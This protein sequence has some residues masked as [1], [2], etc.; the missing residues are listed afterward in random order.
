MHKIRDITGICLFRNGTESDNS[1][2]TLLRTLDIRKINSDVLF[3][4]FVKS[5]NDATRKK[6][7]KFFYVKV[8]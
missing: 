8:F 1:D 2:K 5:I 3:V 7:G 4:C 6:L